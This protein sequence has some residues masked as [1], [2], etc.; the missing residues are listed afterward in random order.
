MQQT[1]LAIVS[2]KNGLSARRQSFFMEFER[3]NLFSEVLYSPLST[4]FTHDTPQEIVQRAFG[5][6]M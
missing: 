4:I 2:A 6:K 1:E 3:K 5:G